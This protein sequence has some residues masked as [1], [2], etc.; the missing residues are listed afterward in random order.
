MRYRTTSPLGTALI[1]FVTATIAGCA[2][3]GELTNQYESARQPTVISIDNFNWLS[4][5]IYILRGNSRFRI[6]T[7]EGLSRKNLRVPEALVWGGTTNLLVGAIGSNASH[8]TGQ[9]HVPDGGRVEWLIRGELAL[10][11]ITI[12]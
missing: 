3:Q 4:V 10:S 12:H 7:V 11:S 8:A 5:K 9:F 6:G 2:H 1:V